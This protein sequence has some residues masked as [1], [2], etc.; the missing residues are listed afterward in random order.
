MN[1]TVRLI[2]LILMV[3]I[4]LCTG[5]FLLR[6]NDWPEA[7]G[8]A[9]GGFLWG[10]PLLLATR[11]LT[12]MADPATRTKALRG[13]VAVT[14]LWLFVLILGATSPRTQ[15]TWLSAVLLIALGLVFVAPYLLNIYVLRR[16]ASESP[17]VR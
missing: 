14:V 4:A 9:V 7:L 11:A 15:V 1:K 6:A 5:W 16:P 10:G 2:N 12:T 8:V 13:N 3:P 17:S